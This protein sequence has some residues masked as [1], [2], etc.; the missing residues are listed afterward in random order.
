MVLGLAIAALTQISC[1]D[2][3]DDHYTGSST[4]QSSDVIGASLWEAIQKDPNLSNFASVIKACGY[5]K[6]LGGS[7]VFTVFAPTNSCFSAEEAQ[8][9]I[10]A[11]NEEKGKVDDD[12]NTTIK[13]F[14]QNHIALYN[15]SVSESSK[16]SIVM[17]NGK[18][19]LLTPSSISGSKFLTTNQHYSN[20]ILFTLGD[21]VAFFSNL[22]EYMRK[23]NDLDSIRSFFYNP[24][25]YRSEFSPSESVP[26]GI[27]DGKTVY[28]DSVFR[29]Q[30]N[31]F[32]FLDA[33][34]NAEDST[35][36][37]VAPTNRVWKELIEEYEPYFNYDDKV[38]DRDSMVYTMPRLA[39]TMG[40]TFSRTFN[41]DES[42]RDSAIS[43]LAYSGNMRKLAWGAD[44]LHYYEYFNPLSAPNGVLTGTTNITCSNGT[45]MKSDNWKF[46][47]KETFF[48][49]RIIEAEEVGVI[50]ELSSFTNSRGDKEETIL[51]RYRD[52]LPD[53]AFYN[54]VS[55]NSFVEFEPRRTTSNHTV[56]FNITDVLSNIGYDVYL[57]TAPALANDSNATEIQRL[58][59]ILRCTLGFHDQTGADQSEELVSSVTTQPDICDHILIAENFK[60][61]VCS[62]GLYEDMPQ[63]TLTVETRVSSSQFKNNTYT[64]TMRIDCIILKPHQE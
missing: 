37:M 64:R 45:M 57:V 46:D 51:P 54:E 21:K 1:S 3:W 24:M 32:S 18:Y 38:A 31:I 39:I 26:G 13:E 12:E 40:T 55:G 33:R 47:K 8:K 48:Q 27:E 9:L 4:D 61:P 20:G 36:L 7:Q 29:L 14:I 23:D 58:P 10:Q 15:Y 5:D 17:M 30:N 19:A 35:Y 6:S 60:F 42:L 50:R 44:S 11:Y 59:T 2:E 53:N 16:D 34:L 28:L 22:F 43:T 49:T 52:V 41:T 25:F 56:V 62:Y 63:V